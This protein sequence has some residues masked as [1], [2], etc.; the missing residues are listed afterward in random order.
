MI[1]DAQFKMRYQE[2]IG[3]AGG[4]D[5]YEIPKSQWVDNVDLS[6]T[7]MFACI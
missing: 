4:L 1:V 2:K 3:L 5:P 7:F 6:H